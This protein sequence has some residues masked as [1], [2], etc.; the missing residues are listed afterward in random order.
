[1]FLKG[2]LKEYLDEQNEYYKKARE[3]E[4]K[5]LLEVWEEKYGKPLPK[6]LELNFNSCL[7]E[8][9][10]SYIEGI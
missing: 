4:R 2:T 1:M 6:D 8:I 9:M 3:D 5:M 10:Q 7:N